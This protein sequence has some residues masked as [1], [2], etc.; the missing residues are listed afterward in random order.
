MLLQQATRRLWP[1]VR[2]SMSWIQKSHR[3]KLL[4]SSYLIIYWR[5]LL[6]KLVF[7]VNTVVIPFISLVLNE[8][9]FTAESLSVSQLSI[10]WTYLARFKLQNQ[11]HL[12]NPCCVPTSLESKSKALKANSVG[13]GQSGPTSMLKSIEEIKP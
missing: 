1:T 6:L 8:L 2:E 7:F 4:S 11:K 3:S 9:D 10:F 12:K 5:K 13:K